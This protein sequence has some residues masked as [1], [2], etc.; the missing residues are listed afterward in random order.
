MGNKYCVT[1]L[2]GCGDAFGTELS[3]EA[4][5]LRLRFYK[6]V[7]TASSKNAR[8]SSQVERHPAAHNYIDWPLQTGLRPLRDPVS[9]SSWH[10]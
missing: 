1:L 3:K 4:T 5:K 10:P 7:T 9:P 2:L 8:R 6:C